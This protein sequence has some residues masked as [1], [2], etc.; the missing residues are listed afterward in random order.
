MQMS[1]RRRIG[2]DSIGDKRL[3][4]LP[5]GP[6]NSIACFDTGPPTSF[7]HLANATSS[8]LH[9]AIEHCLDVG[10]QT[11]ILDDKGHELLRIPANAEEF[12]AM[13]FHKRLK[14]RVSRDTHAMAVLSET[15]ADGNEWL[16]VAARAD[17]LDDN[18]HW[19]NRGRGAE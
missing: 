12:K 13:A 1:E 17:E 5:F 8:F 10:Q 11:R 2:N 7:K 18:I 3:G 16:N 15:Q 9:V 19:R 14:G 6:S 4:I